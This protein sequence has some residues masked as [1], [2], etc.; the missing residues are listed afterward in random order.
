MTV[1]N[2]AALVVAGVGFAFFWVLIAERIE[3]SPGVHSTPGIWFFGLSFL[4]LL[5]L[6]LSCLLWGLYRVLSR[7]RNTR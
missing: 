5:V 3:T 4:A 7:L 6:L 2:K 1:G